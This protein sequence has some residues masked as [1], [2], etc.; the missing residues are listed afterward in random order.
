MSWIHA[1]SMDLIIT[2]YMHVWKCCTA[3][4]K[5][6]QLL[7]VNEKRCFS[8]VGVKCS[9]AGQTTQS[10]QFSVP[11]SL[12]GPQKPQ[13]LLA[14]LPQ[15]ILDKCRE[16]LLCPTAP[17]STLLAPCWM[18]IVFLPGQTWETAVSSSSDRVLAIDVGDLDWDVLPPP[19][20]TLKWR[21]QYFFLYSQSFH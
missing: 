4:Q 18:L 21:N 7:C 11:G 20:T 1:S 10:F 16:T 9:Q 12:L 3:S 19:P 15:N 8:T 17:L 6:I 14:L 13:A 2:C 5:H